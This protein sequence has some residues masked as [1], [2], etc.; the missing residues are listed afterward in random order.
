MP[1][2]LAAKWIE[3]SRNAIYEASKAG[4]LQLMNIAGFQMVAIED[5]R[6][7]LSRKQ[8]GKN[9]FPATSL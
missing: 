7:A 3:C 6:R 1:I 5:V 4:R 2:S 9:P 8:D